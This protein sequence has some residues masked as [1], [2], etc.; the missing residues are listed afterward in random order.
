MPVPAST[1]EFLDVVRKSGLI[2]TDRLDGA[3]R[4]MSGDLDAV[5]DHLVREGLLTYFQAKQLKQGRYKRFM[6][7]GKYRLLELLGVG[8]MGA[9]YLCEHDFMKRL[10][11]VKVLPLDKIASDP[12]ALDRFYREARAVAALDHPNIVRAYDIDKFENVHFLVMEYVDGNS[13]Q[14]IGTR[15]IQRNR[16]FDP[17]RAAHIIAQGAAGLHH[18][19]ALGIVHRDIKPGNLLLD[20]SGTIKILDMGLARF[21]DHRNDGLTERFD[22]KCVLGTADYLAPEQATNEAVDVRADLYG[23]GGTFYFL[24]TGRSPFPD[25]TVAQKLVA[26]QREKPKP[27]EQFRSDVP[28]GLLAVLDKLMRKNPAERYQTPLEVIAALEPWTSQPAAEPEDFEMPLLSPAVLKAMGENPIAGRLTQT[29]ARLATGKPADSHE[30]VTPSDRTQA[31]VPTDR[32]ADTL[33]TRPGAAPTTLPGAPPSNVPMPLSS[34]PWTTASAVELLQPFEDRWNPGRPP[35]P[36]KSSG[37]A[38]KTSAMLVL[39]GLLSFGL[40]TAIIVAIYFALR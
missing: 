37:G 19:N 13:L 36:S 20:R 33:P 5:S 11:A 30:W 24:L 2:S 34:R 23:L 32:T 22:D 6:I 28:A 1:T 8:G 9:V 14:E 38:K 40:A 16:R 39:V 35:V 4:G 7:A 15:S 17:I 26:H 12:T 29:V 3:V 25:G 18:A 21:F 10:V 31:M 27:V